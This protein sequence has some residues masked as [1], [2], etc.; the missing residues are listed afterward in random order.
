MAGNFSRQC[1]NRR[2]V[3]NLSSRVTRAL[4]YAASLTALSTG[5]LAATGDRLGP[6]A[7]A[8]ARELGR[9]GLVFDPGG[10]G[11]GFDGHLS[12]CK[13]RLWIQR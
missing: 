5:F 3:N 2:Q 7:L 1:R 8:L 12:P 13:K 9:T 4:C 10:A 6:L 11:L